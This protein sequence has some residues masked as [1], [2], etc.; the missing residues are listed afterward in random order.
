[1]RKKVYQFM[2]NTYQNLKA[3]EHNMRLQAWTVSIV[4]VLMIRQLRTWRATLLQQNCTQF[5]LGLLFSSKIALYQ[6]L[7]FTDAFRACTT[8]SV[9]YAC[10]IWVCTVLYSKV[11]MYAIGA[12]LGLCYWRLYFTYT[13]PNVYFKSLFFTC[14]ICYRSLF[15]TSD[16]G[17]CSFYCIST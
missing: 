13:V 17:V 2:F 11:Y 15:L 16:I 8:V 14:D 4:Q 3:W 6:S 1:M 5:A 12:C 10:A 9:I 7:Y